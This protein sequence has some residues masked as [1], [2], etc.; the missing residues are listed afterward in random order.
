MRARP[1]APAH[2][3]HDMASTFET[4]MGSLYG[5]NIW[6][7]FVPSLQ[8]AKIQGW[9]GRHPSLARLTSLPGSGIVV[10]VGVWKGQSTLTMAKAMKD[11]GI[12]GVVI[13]VDTFLGSSEHWANEKGLFT[14]QQG[15]P[16]LYDTF[17]SNVV[18]AGLQTQVIPLP[19]T[20]TT[21][22]LILKK[23]GIEPAIIHIDAAHEYNEVLRDLEHWWEV[24]P[25][26]GTIIGDDYDIHWPGVVQAADEFAARMGVRLVAEHPKFILGK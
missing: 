23:L 13:A 24:L 9:N 15:R 5:A 20:S 3:M 26:G 6:D 4:V 10:D 25:K 16:D 1:L 17:L 18:A 19:Q 12:D 22:A 11:N 2:R 7:G 21:A 14:R 8:P